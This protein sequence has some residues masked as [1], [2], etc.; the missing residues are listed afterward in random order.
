MNLWQGTQTSQNS[1]EQSIH[2]LSKVAS[3][4]CKKK[5]YSLAKTPVALSTKKQTIC[6]MHK[7]VTKY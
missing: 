7:R 5:M 2:R 4:K 1:T 6:S 3:E